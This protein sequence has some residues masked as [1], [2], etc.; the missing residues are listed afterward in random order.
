MFN[1]RIRSAW[2][3]ACSATADPGLFSPEQ[4]VTDQKSGPA[5][6][7]GP[8]TA[9]DAARVAEFEQRIAEGESIEPKD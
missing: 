9:E 5:P 7:A 1:T 2:R 8:A 4:I 6:A 3:P